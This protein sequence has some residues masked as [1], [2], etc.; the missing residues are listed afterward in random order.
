MLLY[1]CF[2]IQQAVAL[3]VLFGTERADLLDLATQRLFLLGKAQKLVV[4][5]CALGGEDLKIGIQLADEC[6]V[7]LKLGAQ[8]RGFTRFTA[9]QCRE[10]PLAVC[11]VIALVGAR[12]NLLFKRRALRGKLPLLGGKDL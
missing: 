6:L 2:F 3:Y 8:L 9:L 11:L 1:R 10:Q 4:V 12:L 5:A 7:C